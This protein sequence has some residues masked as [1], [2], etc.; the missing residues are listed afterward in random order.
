MELSDP[1]TTELTTELLKEAATGPFA[2]IKNWYATDFIKRVTRGVLITLKT[3][4]SIID[5]VSSRTR[6]LPDMTTLC[7]NFGCIDVELPGYS[8][9]ADRT[10]ID[11][12]DMVTAHNRTEL[13]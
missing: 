10:L 3:A 13:Q 7:T 12:D 8:F 1:S 11:L 2:S 6:S 4:N 5:M 9:P